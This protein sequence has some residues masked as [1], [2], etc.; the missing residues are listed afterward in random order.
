[1][2]AGRDLPVVPIF[3]NTYLPPLPNPAGDLCI[4]LK[5]AGQAELVEQPALLKVVQPVS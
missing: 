5:L 1:V 2:L 4:A 3:V